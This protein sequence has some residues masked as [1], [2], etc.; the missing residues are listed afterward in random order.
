MLDKNSALFI[1]QGTF[2]AAISDSFY[3]LPHP[4]PVVNTFF[5]F[6]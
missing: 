5:E 6:F 1:F 3:I 2:A 4:Y